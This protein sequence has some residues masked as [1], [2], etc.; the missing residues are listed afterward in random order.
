[1]TDVIALA[2]WIAKRLDPIT[3]E[4]RVT[5][6]GLLIDRYQ[7]GTLTGAA[8][9][10]RWRDGNVTRQVM[11]QGEL[12]VTSASPG[13]GGLSPQTPLSALSAPEIAFQVPE[14]ISKALGRCSFLGAAV[15]LRSAE[16]WRAEIR[17]NPGVNYAQQIL[18][19]EAWVHSH[20]EKRPRKY[21]DR[22]L[23]RWLGNAEREEEDTR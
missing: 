17:A 9:T 20:W 12:G 5:V 22:F 13:T 4:L 8:R 14:S 21:L 23:H 3:P 15:T 19:A 11:Q 10:R 2:H 7:I 1:V 18:K 6:L 16:F